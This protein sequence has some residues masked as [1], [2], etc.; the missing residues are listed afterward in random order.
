MYAT[1]KSLVTG[2]TAHVS[3]IATVFVKHK[4]SKTQMDVCGICLRNKAMRKFAVRIREDIIKVCYP[5][6]IDSLKAKK[7]PFQV[8]GSVCDLQKFGDRCST[9]CYA[10]RNGVCR[11]RITKD[12]DG[13]LWHVWL[14]L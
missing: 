13:K 2:A 5:D 14:T 8:L 6:D 1:F 12:S 3:S 9:L 4:L 7:V 11:A 10:Y